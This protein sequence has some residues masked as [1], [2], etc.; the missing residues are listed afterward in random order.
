MAILALAAYLTWR[1]VWTMPD[2]GIERTVGWILWCFEGAPILALI[3]RWVTLWRLDAD[4]PPR[5]GRDEVFGPVVVFI[6]TY[7]EPA[8]VLA[9]TVA[10]ACRLKP[11]HE[12]WV[13]DDGDREWVRELCAA[14]GARYVQRAEHD[15]AKAGNINHALALLDSEDNSAEFIAIL[16]CDHVPLEGFLHETLGW[17]DR[18]E[19][20]L[21]QA[22]QAYFN[23]RAFDADGYAG[24]QGVFF[25][26]LMVSRSGKKKDPPWCGSTSVVRRTAIREVG[27]IAS[28]TITE[29][30]H[31]TLKLVRQ[32][33]RTV[34]HHQ[35][36]AVG[37]AP[38]TPEQYLIQ[39][40]RWAL[41]AMQVFVGERLWRPKRWLR[42]RNHLEYLISAFW[43]FE[44]AFTALAMVLPATILV[45]GIEPVNVDP[46]VYAALVAAT[47]LF[48]MVGA[49]LLYRGLIRWRHA[50]ELR[51]LRI[52]I[53]LQSMWWLLTRRELAFQVTPK[54]ASEERQ[55]GR[56][57]GVLVGLA[58]VLGVVLVYG[59]LTLIVELPW[60]SSHAAT[61]TGGVW[62]LWGEVMLLM[63]LARIRDPD[64]RS[65]RRVAH[66]FNV[67]AT[68]DVGGVRGRLRDISMTG[69]A[70]AFDGAAAP[71]GEVDVRLPGAETIRMRSVRSV[72]GGV[73]YVLA[74]N[75]VAGIRA[76]TDWIFFTP[77]DPGHHV[78]PGMPAAAVIGDS[79]KPPPSAPARAPGRRDD[80]Q[81]LRALAVGLVV[82]THLGIAGLPG[83]FVGVDVFF[84]ISGFLITGLM[85]REFDLSGVVRLRDFYARR[86]QR[87][88][89]AA[90]VVTAAT[91]LAAG[92]TQS[93][94]RVKEYAHDALW[95]AGFLQNVHLIDQATDYFADTAASPFQHFW[96]LS[97]EEQFY[98]FWPVLLI[99]LLRALKPGSVMLVVGALAALSLGA[100]V[101]LTTT[102]PQEAYFSTYTRAFE[103]A[104]GALVALALMV[105]PHIA[106]HVPRW[107]AW[108]GG[109]AGVC[110]IGLSAAMMSSNDFPSWR[111]L[112]PTVGTVLVLGAG[113][114][115]RVG[116]NW[117]LGLAPLRWLGN[118]SYSLYLWH[119]PV[120][121]LGATLVPSSWTETERILVM[122]GISLAAADLSYR[123]VEN[124]L[125]RR[126]RTS[127]RGLRP[128]VW[129]PVAAV[130]A[131]SVAFAAN[132][133]AEHRQ[134]GAQ[135]DA[136][137]W[138]ADHAGACASS[139]LSAAPSATVDQVR[140]EL[141]CS[142]TLASLGA[143]TPAGVTAEQTSA[144]GFAGGPFCWDHKVTESIIACKSDL[145]PDRPDL[146]LVGDSHMGQWLP[147][148]KEIA[149]NRGL[150]FVPFVKPG[151]PFWEL[152][153]FEGGQNGNDPRCAAYREDTLKTLADLDPALVVVASIVDARAAEKGDAVG[154]GWRRGVA[155]M[156]PRLA[157]LDA[158]VALLADTPL[159]DGSVPDCLATDGLAECELSRP[160]GNVRTDEF[161]QQEA[162]SNSLTWVDPTGLVCSEQHCP[163][164]AAGIGMYSDASHVTRT[165]STHVGPALDELLAGAG[166]LD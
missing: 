135:Q 9:P 111:A 149:E 54:G 51:V 40:R 17:F 69:L 152:E 160:I 22:P 32:G 19:V 57:P 77:Q 44:G 39:R 148:F 164:V 121:I 46:M 88:L 157:G 163:A 25:H 96:S 11:A 79:F 144:D 162:T 92:L 123:L 60:P 20:A 166:V 66:R 50:L 118:I 56:T 161:L 67:P 136:V 105:A 93:S 146:V 142:V 122:A 108:T 7:N 112:V 47:V 110:A 134:A 33:W 3:L 95:S 154:D 10:A 1:V 109:L 119:W 31:T 153:T 129:W 41:G 42:P 158:P 133:F 165:W 14:Y 29:D 97:V 24:E 104:L 58:V 8:A 115:E 86:A 98:V 21:V 63:G 23:D 82:A 62:L 4:P 139:A 138:Y 52:P 145:D 100:S 76:L 59:A 71:E 140:A 5:A 155:G 127:F 28:E 75:E 30:L 141:N 91:L 70:V 132:A 89:P 72:H 45:S 128:L 87:I 126:R 130:T 2:G 80:I 150:D 81:G 16:D 61:L 38:D 113:L 13:L 74:G 48:R 6:P 102:S 36:L 55:E 124:P 114:H 90:I 12:T 125:L 101:S 103:L 37:L 120:I 65:T 15:H 106:F 43:W 49:N 137:N 85:V 131:L 18:P 117:L 156:L 73:A 35:I 26:A 53:G 34:Y 94:I 143:P 84:V 64:F 107:F 78:P 151:C 99:L 116:V 68:V 147:A 83:G 27:G 159:R